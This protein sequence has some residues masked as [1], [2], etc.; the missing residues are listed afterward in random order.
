[1]TKI[2]HICLN[3]FFNEIMGYQENILTKYQARL[4]YSV[5]IISFAM[6][7]D[8]EKEY[9]I[10]DGIKIIRLRSM[11]QSKV[12][13]KY[14]NLIK[15]LEKENPQILFIHGCQFM[16]IG[17]IADWL[18]LKEGIKV[19]IDNHADFL[20]SATN[21][22]SKYILHKIVWRY[23]SNKI[24]PHVIKFYGVTPARVDFLKEIYRL[25]ERKC[26][27]LLMGADDELVS[28]AEENICEQNIRLK[29]NISD[30]CFVI[31][32]GGK[33][34]QYRTEVLDLMRAVI[35]LHDKKIRLVI[36]GK[37][38]DSCLREF[39]ILRRD[40]AIIFV[41][42][43]SVKESYEYMAM[44]DLAFFPGLHSVMWEQ[45]VGQGK[46]IVARR[47]EGFEHIDQ[48]GNSILIEDVSKEGMKCVIETLMK[49]D[50]RLFI[51]MKERAQEVKMNF[52]YKKI[53]KVALED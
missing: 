36:F 28:Q 19:Y 33:I 7:G 41:G 37:I 2:V 13:R 10:N 42:W 53:A 49:D 43:L 39:E 16:D 23:F 14:K 17:K 12:F 38:E 20:N 47:I 45:A 34:N 1:M 29:L 15:N 8:C 44:A 6:E 48:S 26:G 52:S 3:A 22:M 24:E 46:P 21:W 40:T 32:T 31:I 11:N 51:E 25:P 5:S 9:Y 50:F 18:Y 30:D 4:G 35:S 27:L